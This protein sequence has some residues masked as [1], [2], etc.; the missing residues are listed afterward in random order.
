MSALAV[1]GS[2]VAAMLRPGPFGVPFDQV[3]NFSG[4]PG[5][6]EAMDVLDAVCWVLTYVALGLGVLVWPTTA[7]AGR[8]PQTAAG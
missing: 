4:V 7:W 8:R 2:L 5:L 1:V 3:S 6:R